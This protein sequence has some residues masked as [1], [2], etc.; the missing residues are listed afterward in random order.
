MASSG[1]AFDRFFKWKDSRNVLTLTVYT[2]GASECL[3]A[4]VSDVDESH[5]MVGFV[6]LTS[7]KPI[8]L[9]FAGDASFRVDEHRVEPLVPHSETLFLRNDELSD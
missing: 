5:L 2:N 1:E 6:D 9:D 8:G 3:T 7:R 4:Q